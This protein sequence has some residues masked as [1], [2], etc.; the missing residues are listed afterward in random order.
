[1]MDKD[2]HVRIQKLQLIE[3]NLHALLA[4]KQQVQAKL[5]ELESAKDAVAGRKTGYRI[6]G[7]VMVEQPAAEIRKELDEGIERAKKRTAA[8]E[9]QETE[10]KSKAESLQQ[11]IMKGMGE[12]E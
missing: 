7:N 1:M 5:M 4:Q 9:K 10:L 6:V 11:E 12:Q 2:M 3:E 8:L